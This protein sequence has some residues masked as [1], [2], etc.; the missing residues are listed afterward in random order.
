[1]SR[2]NP[3]HYDVCVNTIMLDKY[4]KAQEEAEDASEY[5]YKKIV[6][7]FK[8]ELET[9]TCKE[10]VYDD[11]IFE[12]QCFIDHDSFDA[13]AHEV[14]EQILSDYDIKDAD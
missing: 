8:D 3:R 11:L 4:L 6:Y 14:V 7:M 5:V 13:D 2:F 9:A 12:T 10:D 1:M